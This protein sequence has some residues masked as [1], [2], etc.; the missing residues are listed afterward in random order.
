M[1][2]QNVKD[3]L[4]VRYDRGPVVFSIIFLGLLMLAIDVIAVFVS[5]GDA[6]NYPYGGII[7]AGTTQFMDHFYSVAD[8]YYGAYSIWK[9][10]Y[11]AVA[12]VIYEVFAWFSEDIL[13]ANEREEA[14]YLMRDDSVAMLLLV[15]MYLVCV[16]ILYLVYRRTVRGRLSDVQSDLLFGIVLFS[17][18]LIF[19]FFR[20]NI[21]IL[22]LTLC[23]LFLVGYRSENKWIRLL[24]YVCL[25]LSIGIKITPAILAFL[26]LRDRD[27]RGF[28]E[29]VVVSVVIFFGA[30]LLTDGSFLDMLD[31]IFLNNSLSGDILV[32]VRSI[33]LQTDLIPRDVG[34]AIG[35][36]VSILIIVLSVVAVIFDRGMK[37]WKMAALFFGCMA[38]CTGQA[39]TY[40]YLYMMVPLVLFA[41]EEKEM[42]RYNLVYVLCFFLIFM[43]Y[44]RANA[45]KLLGTLVILIM[46]LWEAFVHIRDQR[47][48]SKGQIQKPESTA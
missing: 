1:E 24:S 36:A 16:Y 21:I 3:F 20:G 26:I 17:G 8:S 11:P 4:R 14:A 44:P 41:V 46:L 18:P 29:C 19:A 5:H 7:Q 15:L 13:S 33:F 43:L 9:V 48:A 42:D 10:Q 34:N 23:V 30:F 37:P 40:F 27:W 28:L 39:T 45:L 22:A 6:L 12:V 25:G 38:V 47:R 32:S 2:T 31:N 35:W